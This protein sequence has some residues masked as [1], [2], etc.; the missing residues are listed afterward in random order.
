MNPTTSLLLSSHRRKSS[1]VHNIHD[2]HAAPTH[3]TLLIHNTHC[4]YKIHTAPTHHTLLL[5]ITRCSYVI[6]TLQVARNPRE[7]TAGVA[8]GTLLKRAGSSTP[9]DGSAPPPTE[10]LV[11]HHPPNSGMPYD[12]SACRPP[13][14]LQLCV[15][16][17]YMHTLCQH[18]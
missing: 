15:N 6:H 10:D 9:L 3:H 13:P 12:A 8:P 11:S 1:T 7:L 14:F 5:H 16:P 18:S 17:T 2:T 4:S